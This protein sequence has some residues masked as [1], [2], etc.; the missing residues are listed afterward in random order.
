MTSRYQRQIL[1]PQLGKDGQEKLG[2]SRVLVIGAGGLG[3]PALM[4]LAGAGIGK[5]GIMD[6]DKV[7][8]HNLHRQTLYS[9]AQLGRPKAECA[10]EALSSLNPEIEYASYH[11]KISLSAGHDVFPD[12]DLIIDGT[13]NFE[14]KFLINELCVHHCKPL[15]YG[16]VQGFE[17]HCG[18]FCGKPDWP[19]Y[20]CLVPERPKANIMNCAEAGILGPV[21][22]LVGTMQA[23]EAIK[24]FCGLPTLA[25]RLWVWDGIA[26][27]N[28]VFEVPKSPVCNACT[29]FGKEM[30]NHKRCHSRGVPGNAVKIAEISPAEAMDQDAVFIDVREDEEWQ[31]GHIKEARHYPL[32]KML[33]DPDKIPR[34]LND[35][36]KERALILYCQKGIRSLHAADLMASKGF[37]NLFSMRGG[38]SEWTRTKSEK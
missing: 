28:T 6:D 37:A 36:T 29:S 7:A 13:D 10:V 20:A 17:G 23:L 2:N 12:Y 16:S 19:C 33:T 26:Q 9:E 14:A 25:G 35:L 18:V 21:A 34:E 4:Y 11:Q 27:K 22:G 38:Y 24:Y 31:A 1:L 5:I 32:S 8:R 3:S 15:I 30:R